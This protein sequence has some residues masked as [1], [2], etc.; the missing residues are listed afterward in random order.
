MRAGRKP[1]Y[2]EQKKV[3]E[4]TLTPTARKMLTV[5]AKALRTSAS[6]LVERFARGLL[7]NDLSREL[8]GKP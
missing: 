7:D 1:T 5:K 4:L 2:G 6:E 8:T 3:Y